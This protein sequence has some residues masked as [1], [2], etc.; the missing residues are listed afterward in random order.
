MMRNISGSFLH[1]R[2]WASMLLSLMDDAVS[3][4]RLGLRPSIALA[5]ENLFLRKPLALYEERQIK[6]K[7][8]TH[9]S[10]LAMVWLSCWFDWRSPY[11]L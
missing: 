5:A 4:L 1:I 3:Y 11:A 2:Q 10:R 7:R 8:A 6:P 9:A